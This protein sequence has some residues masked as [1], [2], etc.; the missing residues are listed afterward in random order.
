M[1]SAFRVYDGFRVCACRVR[2]SHPLLQLSILIEVKEE[3]TLL[4]LNLPQLFKKRLFKHKL[5]LTNEI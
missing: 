4:K 1:A 5:I 2:D 3:I